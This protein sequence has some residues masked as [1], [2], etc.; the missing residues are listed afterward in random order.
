MPN[1][2]CASWITCLAEDYLIIHICKQR[3]RTYFITSHFL[4]A[5]KGIR[6]KSNIFIFIYR[7]YP[8]CQY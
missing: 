8:K 5:Q 1:E 2:L 3:D 4:I 6:N 7:E